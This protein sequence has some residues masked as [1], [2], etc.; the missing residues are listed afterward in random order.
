VILRRTVDFA[1]EIYAQLAEGI[2]ADDPGWRFRRRTLLLFL[3]HIFTFGRTYHP[4]SCVD[5]RAYGMEWKAWS[6]LLGGCLAG[7]IL[8]K[9][10]SSYLRR[11][12]ADV[13]TTFEY[14]LSDG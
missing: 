11:L 10:R 6:H 5:V 3:M 4:G 7:Y 1:F 9:E 13:I 12:R 8:G 2:I 14:L